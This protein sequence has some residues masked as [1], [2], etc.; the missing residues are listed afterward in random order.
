MFRN[1]TP[2]SIAA[3]MVV[4]VIRLILVL[5][6]IALAFAVG[7][8]VVYQGHMENSLNS[9]RGAEAQLREATPNKGGHRERALNL[10]TEAISQV[11]AGIQYA[12]RN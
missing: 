1:S 12:D 2:S 11:E 6:S 10:V 3:F 7:R 4:R 9:L 8:A 5:A